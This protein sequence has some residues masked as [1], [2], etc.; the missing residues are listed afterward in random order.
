[1]GR[2]RAYTG[3]TFGGPRG[4]KSAV[5]YDGLC[6]YSPKQVSRAFLNGTVPYDVAFKMLVHNCA[7]KGTE[8]YSLLNVAKR[9]GVPKR[10]KTKTANQ[11][12]KR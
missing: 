2:N 1:M 6:F 7:L 9:A 10:S 3:A 11:N 5:E 12:R 8:A 4:G